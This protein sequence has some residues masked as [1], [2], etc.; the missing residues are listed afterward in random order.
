MKIYKNVD[1]LIS[2]LLRENGIPQKCEYIN[3]Q[4]LST[5]GIFDDKNDIHIN[6]NSDTMNDYIFLKDMQH[7]I[8]VDGKLKSEEI[9][10]LDT[11]YEKYEN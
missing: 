3:S 8:S 6:K 9:E 10:K 4:L 7:I 5:Y 11:L 2:E 1:F